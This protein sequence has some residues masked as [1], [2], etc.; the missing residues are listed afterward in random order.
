MAE[1]QGDQVVSSKFQPCRRKSTLR[2]GL[3]R[4]RTPKPDLPQA[5]KLARHGSYDF[6]L[7]QTAFSSLPLNLPR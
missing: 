6:L 2:L 1:V 3:S 5:P 4:K 7:G